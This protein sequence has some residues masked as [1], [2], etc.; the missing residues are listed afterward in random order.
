MSGMENYREMGSMWF[1]AES[2]LSWKYDEE[3]E[4][5]F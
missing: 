5:F 3:E 1:R 2:L 4:Q